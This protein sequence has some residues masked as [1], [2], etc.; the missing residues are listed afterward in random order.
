MSE[1]GKI[2]RSKL[3]LCIQCKTC[4]ANYFG[5]AIYGG[6]DIDADS[7]MEI[8]EAHNRGDNVFLSEDIVLDACNCKG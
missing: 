6:L 3:I 4:K 2:V 5:Q 7:T 8:A 1:Q